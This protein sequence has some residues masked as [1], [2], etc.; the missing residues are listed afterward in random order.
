MF[1]FIFVLC[2]KDNNKIL[3]RQ[4]FRK[5]NTEKIV[6]LTFINNN[7]IVLLQICTI[8]WL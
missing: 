3:N 8:I 6:F 5:E 4:I 2:C 1:D 7:M